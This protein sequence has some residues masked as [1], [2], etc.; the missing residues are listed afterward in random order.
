MGTKD[1]I[2]LWMLVA[3][4]L[5]LLL[6]R[7]GSNCLNGE[8]ATIALLA[9]S[10]LECG[11]PRSENRLG[12]ITQ[13]WGHDANRYGVWVLT[14]WLP[15]YL[16]A[17]SFKILGMSTL[18]ARLPFALAGVISV[19]LLFATARKRNWTTGWSSMVALLLIG[20]VQFLLFC[21]RVGPHG[22]AVLLATLIL[23]ECLQLCSN[24]Q[25]YNT[26][27][28]F[29]RIGVWSGVL[30][31]VDYWIWLLQLAGL[32]VYCFYLRWAGNLGNSEGVVSVPSIALA[33]AADMCIVL[34]FVAFV[35]CTGGLPIRVLSAHDTPAFY[36]VM[37]PFGGVW[38]ASQFLMGTLIILYTVHFLCTTRK[39]YQADIKTIFLS[40]SS[41]LGTLLTYAVLLKVIA[42]PTRYLYV[43]HL[44]PAWTLLCAELLRGL[45]SNGRLLVVAAGLLLWC[46]NLG[47]V[48]LPWLGQL[49]ATN[50][51]FVPPQWKSYQVEYVVE[52]WQGRK[53]PLDR[54]VDYLRERG[55]GVRTAFASYEVEPLMFH[56]RSVPIRVLPLPVTPDLVVLRAGWVC[57]YERVLVASA[58]K[59]TVSE[60]YRVSWQ[61]A[62]SGW[63]MDA[64]C[65]YL[66]KFLETSG[67]RHV[68]LPPADHWYQN[69]DETRTRYFCPD[70]GLRRVDLWLRSGS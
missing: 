51:H 52:L 67:Y 41:I 10:V 68:V 62:A 44:M 56:L 7:L 43:A 38:E 69:S 66:R 34:P 14:P 28:T 5:V 22:L 47:E 49:D 36:R 37:Y 2:A 21:R 8:E 65:A 27:S 46:T 30:F 23:R 18:A 48:W 64:H 58:W 31:Y 60:S 26:R 11:Y 3:F 13:E 42:L 20:N 6:P 53:G 1:R 35:A 59:P 9:Q 54:L 55:K 29:L 61:R 50:R 45:A 33:L 17:F 19:I 4:S 12:L 39:R 70:D 25:A 63:E 16:C 32:L 15:I 40:W 24:G 57:D